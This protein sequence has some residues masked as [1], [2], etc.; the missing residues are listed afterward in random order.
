MRPQRSVQALL[1]FI[2]IEGEREREEKWV[3][4]RSRTK[5]KKI[6]FSVSSRQCSSKTLFEAFWKLTEE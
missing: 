4:F 2:I 3:K 6:S 5:N 1:A